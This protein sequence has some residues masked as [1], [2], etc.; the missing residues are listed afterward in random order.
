MRGRTFQFGGSLLLTS[1]ATVLLTTFMAACGTANVTSAV[2]EQFVDGANRVVVSRQVVPET[3]TED[4]PALALYVDARDLLENEGFAF[5]TNDKTSRVIETM[6]E[7]VGDGVTLKIDLVANPA[8]GGSKLIARGQYLDPT[9]NSWKPATW[10]DGLA[11][12][13]FVKTYDA[14][15]DLSHSEVATAVGTEMNVTEAR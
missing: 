11:G 9:T 7:D 15:V 10:T 8:P 3:L 13:A 14:L 2:K 6:P 4:A 5:A 1:V 12:R